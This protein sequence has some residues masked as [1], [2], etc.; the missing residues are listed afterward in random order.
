MT[1]RSS[2]QACLFSTRP[3]CSQVHRF[4]AGSPM[5]HP[6]DTSMLAKQSAR[7]QPVLNL[8]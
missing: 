7:R 2:G 8:I 1:S 6:V 4:D 3:H 5:S